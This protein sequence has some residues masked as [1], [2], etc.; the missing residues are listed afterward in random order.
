MPDPYEFPRRPPS[1]DPLAERILEEIE[2]ARLGTAGGRE[3][4]HSVI[5]F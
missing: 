1:D 2:R 3:A 5:W 4:A